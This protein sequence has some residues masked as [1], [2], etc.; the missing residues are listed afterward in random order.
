LG[1]SL[2]LA[3]LVVVFAAVDQGT[4]DARA[5]LAHRI[6]AAFAAGSVMLVLAL[7][8]VLWLIVLPQRRRGPV[9]CRTL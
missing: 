4:L 7:A 6:A 9:A 5:L 1:G 3:I 2:G 8:A